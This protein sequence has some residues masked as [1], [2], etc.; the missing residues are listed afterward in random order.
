MNSMSS[1]LSKGKNIPNANNS[2]EKVGRRGMTDRNKQQYNTTF[3]S[4]NSMS[5][6]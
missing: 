4:N 2:L 6:T 1:L 5:K 3:E